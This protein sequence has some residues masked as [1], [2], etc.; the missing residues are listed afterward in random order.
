MK[1]KVTRKPLEWLGDSLDVTSAFPLEVKQSIGHALHLA[2]IGE[3]AIHARPM[4]GFSGAG[5]LEIVEDDDGNTYRAVYTVKFR[6]I[7]FVLHAFQKKSTKGIATPK[8][9]VDLIKQRLKEAVTYY[10]D[11]FKGKK[12]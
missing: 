4:Q 7:V 3:K 1:D 11:H 8:R 2:Q 12:R 9:H 10:D 5:V 6:G